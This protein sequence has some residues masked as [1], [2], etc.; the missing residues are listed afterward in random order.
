SMAPKH[1]RAGWI[2]ERAKGNE[3]AGATVVAV[4]F[5]ALKA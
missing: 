3:D 4:A 2:G 5:E 1:G